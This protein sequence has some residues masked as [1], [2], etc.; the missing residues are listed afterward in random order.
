MKLRLAL[1]AL[2][3]FCLVPLAQAQAPAGGAPPATE[4]GRVGILNFR[5]A[6]VA[7]AEG[8]Q[9]SAELQSQ[10]ASRQTELENIR[11]QI[12]DGQKRLRDGERTLSDE[13][14]IRLQRQID[15][16]T[17]LGQRKQEDFQEDLNAAQDEVLQ[18]IGGKMIEVVDRYARENGYTLVLD[19]SAQT[20]PVIFASPTV[21]IT[22]EII[23]LHD[24]A[25]PVKA[26]APQQPP[27]RP[28]P[29]QTKPPQQPPAQKPPPQ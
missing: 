26:A 14:K 19:V 18:R 29:G 17:R 1:A 23:R 6:I 10:F 16:L 4:A 28:Q 5:Q 3:A 7:T 12:E 13:E 8:K 20:S 25:H 21:N 9:A 15:Q 22:Q 11:K 2:A 27:A 24:Q